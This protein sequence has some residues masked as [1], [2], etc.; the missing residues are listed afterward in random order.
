MEINLGV[1]LE[2]QKHKTVMHYLEQTDVDNKECISQWQEINVSALRMGW[3]CV[4]IIT[5]F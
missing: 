3:I 2:V 5:V 4:A 1:D